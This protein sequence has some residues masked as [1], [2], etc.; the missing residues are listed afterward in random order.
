MLNNDNLPDYCFKE[1]RSSYMRKGP[2]YVEI[3]NRI[4]ELKTLD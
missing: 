1:S 2:K 3:I 4:N